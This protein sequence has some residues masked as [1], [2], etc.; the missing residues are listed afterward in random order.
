VKTWRIGLALLALAILPFGM[1][2]A[3]ADAKAETRA[4]NDYLLHCSGCHGQDGMGKPEKGIP[5]FEGQVG[6]FLRVPEGRAF[7]MQVPGLL[8]ANMSDERAAAVTS[9]MIR[10]FSGPSLPGDFVPYTA[11][12]AARYRRMRPAEITAKRNQLYAELLALGYPLQ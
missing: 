11:E 9:W 10:A 2:S 1:E 5:R 4:R 12:E 7:L 3:L 8:S 6:Y